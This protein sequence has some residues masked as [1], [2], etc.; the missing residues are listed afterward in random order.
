ML[1]EITLERGIPSDPSVPETLPIDRVF[2]FK[3]NST[4][5]GIG[6]SP[7]R[8]R[9]WIRVAPRAARARIDGKKALSRDK[10]NVDIPIVRGND[11]SVTIRLPFRA[12]SRRVLFFQG[13]RCS[14][15]RSIPRLS[16]AKETS[17]LPETRPPTPPPRVMR[18]QLPAK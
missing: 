10:S 16:S 15:I 18:Y 11:R 9:H 4:Y 12:H 7:I 3:T 13:R 1:F 6:A 5:I 17:Y 8:A 2:R 14:S